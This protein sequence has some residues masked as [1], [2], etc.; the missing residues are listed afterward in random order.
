MVDEP[1]V[2]AGDPRI[3]DLFAACFPTERAIVLALAPR[4][5][6]PW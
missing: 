4:V 6:E 5:D 2:L 1:E 3:T